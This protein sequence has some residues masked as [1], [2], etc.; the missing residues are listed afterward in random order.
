MSDEANVH[1]YSMLD[2]LIEGHQWIKNQIGECRIPSFLFLSRNVVYFIEVQCRPLI[3]R[4]PIRIDRLY[5]SN[6]LGLNHSYLYA[7]VQKQ[8]AYKNR[9]IMIP[10]LES[11][12][13]NARKKLFLIS[14]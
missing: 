12:S 10:C 6:L 9:R 4:P 11:D 2:Q 3:R 1:Y 5:E 8:T 13:E 7:V 14:A